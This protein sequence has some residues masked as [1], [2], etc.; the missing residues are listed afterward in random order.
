[1]SLFGS[2]LP[3]FV[4]SGPACL[5][6]HMYSQPTSF[7]P[8]G[9][10]TLKTDTR[11]QLPLVPAYEVLT[12]GHCDVPPRFELASTPDPQS[13]TFGFVPSRRFRT[14]PP[15]SS[16]L[17]TGA[18]GDLEERGRAGL[19]YLVASN[20]P[21]ARRLDSR[22]LQSRYGASRR[23]RDI[24]SGY[25]QHGKNSCSLKVPFSEFQASYLAPP[26]IGYPTQPYMYM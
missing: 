3:I 22:P 9:P 5:S 20:G 17:A 1:M 12:L 10:R 26:L 21:A 6:Q 11:H 14:L 19:T 8:S 23:A 4:L 15:P 24:R 18:W 25:L 7:L 13:P 16:S 2:L